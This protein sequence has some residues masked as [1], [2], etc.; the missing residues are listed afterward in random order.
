[1]PFLFSAPFVSLR[2]NQI[3]TDT[4]VYASIFRDCGAGYFGRFEYL[5]SATCY[6]SSILSKSQYFFYF[7]M[8]SI[9]YFSFSHFLDELFQLFNAPNHKKKIYRNFVMGF[10]LASN[11][12]L[13]ASV[14]GLRQGIALPLLYTSLLNLQ[15]KKFTKSFIF[16]LAALGFHYSITLVMPFLLFLFIKSPIT[17]VI[18][19]LL[20]FYLSVSGINEQLVY[21]MSKIAI[22]AFYERISAY[23]AGQ[24]MWFGPQTEHLLYTIFWLIL[25]AILL[26][27][28]GRRIKLLQPMVSLYFVCSMPYYWFGFA[29]YSNR[30][31]FFA[32]LL[33]PVIIG[34]TIANL[35]VEKLSS[36]AT[37]MLILLLGILIFISKIIFMNA[38][39]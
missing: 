38:Q 11:W 21:A 22:P 16:L 31:A 25:P 34:I 23:G 1:M 13:S 36:G 37:S 35:K 4:E 20:S 15:S 24:N 12:Y 33:V 14:N 9:L 26:L 39:I 32:W 6:A 17:I 2:A 5:F 28:Y 8:Y 7:V 27:A 29:N 10:I 19:G 18:F 30:Y 3:G